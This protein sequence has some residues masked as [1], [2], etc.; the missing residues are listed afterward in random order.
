MLSYI[1]SYN[2]PSRHVNFKGNA[3]G[4]PCYFSGTLEFTQTLGGTLSIS[5]IKVVVEEGFSDSFFG[6]TINFTGQVSGKDLTI[7]FP[8]FNVRVFM[9]LNYSLSAQNV[10]GHGVWVLGQWENNEKGVEADFYVGIPHRDA[11]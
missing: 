10:S 11:P 5:S 4:D 3:A 8:N 2:L 1:I 9:A 6:R 7:D